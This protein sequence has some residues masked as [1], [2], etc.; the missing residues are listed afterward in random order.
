[1]DKNYY[2]SEICI[3]FSYK[4]AMPLEKN[5]FGSWGIYGEEPN[6]TIRGVWFWKGL[7]ILPAIKELDSYEYNEYIKLDIVNNADHRKLLKDHWLNMVDDD[8]ADE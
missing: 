3:I 7:D 1:M 6:L 8:K 4:N 5:A 2:H